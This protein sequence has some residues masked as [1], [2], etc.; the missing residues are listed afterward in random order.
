MAHTR[1]KIPPAD[2][3]ADCRHAANLGLRAFS[4]DPYERA[5]GAGLSQFPSTDMVPRIFP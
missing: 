3:E 2:S 5:V 4:A 1:P